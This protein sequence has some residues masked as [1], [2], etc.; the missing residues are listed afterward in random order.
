VTPEAIFWTTTTLGSHTG[1]PPTLEGPDEVPWPHEPGDSSGRSKPIR[2]SRCNRSLIFWTGHNAAAKGW[3]ASKWMGA[4][5]CE[6]AARWLHRAALTHG[7]AISAVGGA[8]ERVRPMLAA[9]RPQD[10]FLEPD[11]TA[12]RAGSGSPPG[13]R[14]PFTTDK[15]NPAA[16]R[17]TG[18]WGR[19]DQAGA[20]GHR[21]L[22]LTRGGR[23]AFPRRSGSAPLIAV[24]GH[25]TDVEEAPRH[26]KGV[27]LARGRGASI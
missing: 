25:A 20:S 13:G 15:G 3:P 6:R 2:L 26:A 18:P 5:G 10:A 1:T 24:T 22:F 7:S 12:G 21:G 19:P 8:L 27:S 4:S 17:A 11:P 23:H 9:I 16:E 14:V